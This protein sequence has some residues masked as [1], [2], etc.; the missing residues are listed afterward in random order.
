MAIFM[1]E[2]PAPFLA[3]SSSGSQQP[4]DEQ[5]RLDQCR[6]SERQLNPEYLC[7]IPGPVGAAHAAPPNLTCDKIPRITAGS[8]QARLDHKILIG[9]NRVLSRIVAVSQMQIFLERRSEGVCCNIGK[10]TE[11]P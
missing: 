3:S 7:G 5:K 6:T 9:R 2:H 1:A 4:E 8:S 10:L 11:Q